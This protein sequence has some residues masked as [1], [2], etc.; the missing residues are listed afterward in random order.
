MG[1]GV[2]GQLCGRPL[3]LA[4]SHLTDPARAQSFENGLKEVFSGL[5]LTHHTVHCGFEGGEAVHGEWVVFTHFGPGHMGGMIVRVE[6]GEG[7]LGGSICRG[8][9][10]RGE[11]KV[12]YG[13]HIIQENQLSEG[14]L[15]Y[16][17][18]NCGPAS[19]RAEM[20][21]SGRGSE[22]SLLIN[23]HRY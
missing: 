6:G 14:I 20:S 13:V 12:A 4:C 8:G 3:G 17:K 23:R 15:S 2:G 7:I 19:P 9:G 22:V 11:S 18:G 10:V 21:K 16:C 5:A 1:I